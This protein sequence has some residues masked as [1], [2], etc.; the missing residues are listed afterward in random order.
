M[1]A[2]IT[3]QASDRGRSCHYG[4]LFF[5]RDSTH[6]HEVSASDG[7]RARGRGKSCMNPWSLRVKGAR[8]DT[9]WQP[10]LLECLRHRDSCI[11]RCGDVVVQVRS[12][13]EE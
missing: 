8:E 6:G 13:S 10:M 9:E 1:T 7:R 5:R 12:S 2:R 11:R 4:R 3:H